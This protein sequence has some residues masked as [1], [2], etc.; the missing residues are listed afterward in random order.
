MQLLEKVII[1]AM[2]S[3]TWPVRL[4]AQRGVTYQH[5]IYQAVYCFGQ[6]IHLDSV[7][8]DIQS[9]LLPWLGLKSLLWNS[10]K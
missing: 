6:G 4:L 2:I 10:K 1:I 7:S 5:I 8:T 3:V 9:R